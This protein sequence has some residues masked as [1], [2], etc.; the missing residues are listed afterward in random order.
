MRRNVAASFQAAVVDVLVEKSVV[1]CLNTGVY[2]LA[3][4]GGV[5]SSGA[6]RRAVGASCNTH[7]IELNIPTPK[8]CTDNAA[9]VAAAAYEDYMSRNFAGVCLNAYAGISK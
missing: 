3:V 1:A 8:L 4:V 6:L 5:A 9:M 7:G 2:K